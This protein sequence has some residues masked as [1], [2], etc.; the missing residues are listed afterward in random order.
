[1]AADD[2]VIYSNSEKTEVKIQRQVAEDSFGAVPYSQVKT[3]DASN[4]YYYTNILGNSNNNII[5]AS[6]AGGWIWGYAGNNTVYGNSSGDYFAHSASEGNLTIYNYRVN[7]S[8]LDSSDII[9]LDDGKYG[10][11]SVSGNDVLIKHGSSKVRVVDGAMRY[12]LVADVIGQG[13]ARVYYINT[14]I[15]SSKE[16]ETEDVYISDYFDFAKT[17]YNEGDLVKLGT[18]YAQSDVSL[19]DALPWGINYTD[20]NKTV[21]KITDNYS[22]PAFDAKEYSAL[23]TIDAS[24]TYSDFTITGNVLANEI[25]AGKGADSI[26]GGEGGDTIRVDSGTHTIFG[27]AGNDKIYI[28]G[29][30]RHSIDGGPDSDTIKIDGG[31]YHTVAGGKYGDTITITSGDYVTVDGGTGEDTLYVDGG[32]GHK[33]IG[34][35]AR[36]IIQ[37]NSGTNEVYGGSAYDEITLAS[38][39]DDGNKVYGEANADKI[40]IRGGNNH[41]ING[42]GGDDIITVSGGAFSEV[43]GKAGKDK[44]Y[45]TGGDSHSADGGTDSDTIVISGGSN[46]KVA[47][48]MYG[49]TITITAGNNVHVD[50]GTGEDTLI[51]NGGT[52]H[53][54]IGGQARDVITINA[55]KNEVYGGSAYDEITIEST[56]AAGNII[57]GEANADKIVIHGGS[58][59][60]IN[61]GS[62]D[63]IITVTG[64]TGH[65]VDGD[66][67][68]DRIFVNGGS[69][70]SILLGGGNNAVT[71]SGKNINIEKLVD[72]KDSVTI[73]WGSDNGTY[74]IKSASVTEDVNFRDQLI[75]NG[76]DSVDF[77]FSMSSDMLTMSSEKG[78][79]C[80]QNWNRHSFDGI[81]FSD[82]NISYNSI[83]SVYLNR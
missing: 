17:V 50:S 10:G 37:I 26:Y 76:A 3:I 2:A 20:T 43:Y 64:G 23:K 57:Y 81:T 36:D 44:I 77:A 25:I 28:S 54:V 46:H 41:Y 11:F 79:I 62:G 32:T 72:A 29:G 82:G 47:G 14:S 9:V 66:V 19:K 45:I 18:S 39:V 80:I 52:G 22:L 67:G 78:K 21:A 59:H 68:D 75:I 51:V 53:T 40:V 13:K 60:Y 27:E 1:M 74:M 7:T 8:S 70:H 6:K 71:V 5:K 55:G 58:N 30:T 63:D 48:G 61:G 15:S 49:D 69:G 83:N 34:G 56:A 42:G 4:S 38:T 35:Q 33:V 16:F 24:N 31:S 12:I 65:I 73:K